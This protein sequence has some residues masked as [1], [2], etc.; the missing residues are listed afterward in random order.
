MGTIRII[1]KIRLDWVEVAVILMVWVNQLQRSRK[2]NH[3]KDPSL[4]AEN[5]PQH[6]AMEPT[7]DRDILGSVTAG[8]IPGAVSAIDANV[9]VHLVTHQA[10]EN[11]VDVIISDKAKPAAVGF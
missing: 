9:F 2:M 11:T 8:K 6:G 10:F 7:M 5:R 3:K 1:Y 4:K